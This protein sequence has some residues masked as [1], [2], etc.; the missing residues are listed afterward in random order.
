MST[1]VPERSAEAIILFCLLLKETNPHFGKT[2]GRICSQLVDF[3]ACPRFYLNVG[4][5]FPRVRGRETWQLNLLRNIIFTGDLPPG[6]AACPSSRD[7]GPSRKHP[8]EN[9]GFYFVLK[10]WMQG[11]MLQ[12]QALRNW[13]LSVTTP[14]FLLA[15]GILS[16]PNP[17]WPLTRAHRGKLSGPQAHL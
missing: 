2:S 10:P 6:P 9:M 13:I 15:L 7:L 14:P 3:W 17:G 4:L 5:T 8:S 1:L 11:G 12:E 16:I